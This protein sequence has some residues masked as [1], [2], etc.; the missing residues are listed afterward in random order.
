MRNESILT[1]YKQKE[2]LIRSEN[3]ILKLINEIQQNLL[4][5]D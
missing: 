5:D 4:E 3:S 1:F 2:N